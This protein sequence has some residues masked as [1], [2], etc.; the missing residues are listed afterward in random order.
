MM[1][2]TPNIIPGNSVNIAP[3]SANPQLFRRN[4]EIPPTRDRIPTAANTTAKIVRTTQPTVRSMYGRPSIHVFIEPTVK[5]ALRTKA[6]KTRIL[7]K[8]AMNF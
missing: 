7:K 4:A 5:T 6:I 3:V 1:E 8:S 2:R